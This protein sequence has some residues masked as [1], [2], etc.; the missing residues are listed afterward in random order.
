M[1][2]EKDGKL[3][4]DLCECYISL[5]NDFSSECLSICVPCLL[6]V[7]S[8]KE[9]HEETQKEVE[10]AL[11][12]L[13][14]VRCC[15]V[16]QELYLGA[17][18]EII[19]YHQEHHNL[20]RLAYQS[21]W[22]FLINRLFT[23]KRLEDMI[24][25]ELHFG[26]EASREL[27][28]LSK[29][30]DWKR[31]KAEEEEERGKERGEELVIWRWLDAMYD[32][33]YSCRLW[34][35]ELAGVIGNVVSVFQASRDNRK[36]ISNQCIYLFKRAAENVIMKI[37]VLLDE[38]V[39]DLI[40]EEMKQSTLKDGIMFESLQ[41]LKNIS[42]KLKEKEV[43][44]PEEEKRKAIKRKIFEKMEEEGCEELITS[45]YRVISFL[46]RKYWYCL[47]TNISDYFVGV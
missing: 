12:A 11:L 7:A 45:L 25:N 2:K 27:E 9:R 16:E 10:M 44:K 38:G 22:Q 5:S 33:L 37:D 29:C 23:D 35:E 4:I 31:E 47:S 26:R 40:L 30:V 21:A 34:N 6:K 18:K 8:N 15:V 1:K 13:S 43:D 28:E 39:V 36:R 14:N 20:T 42:R 32:F 17:I 41:F 19:Q 24:V 3:L 46:N